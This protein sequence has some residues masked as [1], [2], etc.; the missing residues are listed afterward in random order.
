VID[1]GKNAATVTASDQSSGLINRFAGEGRSVPAL[2][3]TDHLLAELKGRTI[4]SGVVTALAQA[5]QFG[6]NLGS[7]MVLARLLAPEDF[8]LIAMVLTI[9]GFL[10]VFNDGGLSTATVQREGITHAQVSNLFWTNIALGG[11]MTLFLAAFAPVIAWFYREPRLIGVTLALS[12]SF[13]LISSAV[14]HVALLKRQML[15]KQLAFIQISSAAAG[16]VVGVSMA[17]LKLGYWSLVGM[18]L[19]APIVALLLTWS[20]SH[21]HPQ[22]PQR[23]S[24]TRSLLNFGANL[25]ASSFLWSLARGSDCLLIGRFYGSLSLGLYSRAANLLSRPVEQLINPIEAVFVP[26]LSRLQPQPERYRRIYLQV[27]EVFAVTSF[28]FSGLLLPLSHPLICVVLGRKWESAAPIFA[29]FTVVALYTPVACAAGWLLTSQG[30][31]RDFLRLSSISSS[32]TVVAFLIGLPFGPAALAIAYSASC[33][34]ISLP[35]AYHIAGRCGPV[36][37]RDL[38]SRFLTHL[39]L[40]AIVCGATFVSHR[41]VL[42]STPLVQLLISGSAGL[43]VGASFICVYPPARQTAW[44]LFAVLRDWIKARKAPTI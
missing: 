3:E 35:V 10:R 15:F 5:V 6:L 17:L 4:S 13:L 42:S 28:L 8:G 32:V 30:R 38:W 27:Y 7:I 9:M 24:G 26:A 43:L 22:L 12:V 34:L 25:S 36:L 37:T 41:L 19:S 2:F 21:W 44:E 14:Q 16:L 31:G 39:P 33:L 40:W 23:G 20:A 29:G 1:S 11:V 18:Q